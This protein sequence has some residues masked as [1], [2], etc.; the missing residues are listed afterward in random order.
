MK[1]TIISNIEVPASGIAEIRELVPGINITVERTNSQLKPKWNPFFNDTWADFDDLRDHFI[2]ATDIRCFMT[3]VKKLQDINITTHW[4][5]YDNFDGDTVIDFYIGIPEILDKRA[6]DNGFKTNLAW[7]F[8]HEMLHGKEL[9]AHYKDRTHVMQDQ[10]R[11][12][13]LLLEH[14]ERDKL[15]EKVGLLTRIK[16]LLQTILWYTKN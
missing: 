16:S 6:K 8:I 4:G 10:G 13:E 15:V 11:L 1:A 14:I 12:K 3:S 7:M 5:M 9:L 2:S